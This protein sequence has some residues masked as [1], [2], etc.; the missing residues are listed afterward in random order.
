MN[1]CVN[2]IH[3]IEKEDVRSEQNYF[4]DLPAQKE[5]IQGDSKI[6]A[7]RDWKDKHSTRISQVLALAIKR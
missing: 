4:F 7:H 5:E 1:R 6:T 2:K 3:S